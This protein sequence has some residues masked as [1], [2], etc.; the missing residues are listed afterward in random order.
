MVKMS[1]VKVLVTIKEPH[2][3][4]NSTAVLMVHSID[5]GVV[6]APRDKAKKNQQH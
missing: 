5:K 1:T 2:I 6:V 4:D 3:G